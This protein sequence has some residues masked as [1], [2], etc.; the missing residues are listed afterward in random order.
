MKTLWAGLEQAKALHSSFLARSIK[1]FKTNTLAR[2][3]MCRGLLHLRVMLLATA[4]QE[5]EE[6]IRAEER[7]LSGGTG[8]P[9]AGGD[10][11]QR[12]EALK[13]E[14]AL[15]LFKGGREL[16]PEVKVERNIKRNCLQ[17]PMNA[18]TQVSLSGNLCR[19]RSRRELFSPVAPY[20]TC[21]RL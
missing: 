21:S 6:R 20:G 19:K 7:L 18:L 12:L 2:E 13:D 5:I 15:W 9:T 4:H 16:V 14:S 17:P 1:Y 10:Y 3:V 8:R 11:L